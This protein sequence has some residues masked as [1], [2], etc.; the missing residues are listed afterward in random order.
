MSPVKFS[1]GRA[2]LLLTR[3]ALGG[4]FLYAAWTK[5]SQPWALFAMSINAYQL[6][7]EWSVTLLARTL[8]WAELAL[9][10]LLIA[11]WALRMAATIASILLAG[12]FAVMLRSFLAGNTGIDCGCFGVGEALSGQ[13]LL[14]DAA[15]GMLSFGLTLAAFRENK[16]RADAPAAQPAAFA[17]GEAGETAK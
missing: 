11:G 1:S 15:L 12:F 13:T 9:G 7:P 5:L 6:L 14:R 8:P 3:C 2:V 10:A 4:V 16:N 17:A